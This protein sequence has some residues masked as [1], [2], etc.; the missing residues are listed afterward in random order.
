MNE[1]HQRC[2]PAATDARIVSEPNGYLASAACCLSGLSSLAS[3]SV[4]WAKKPCRVRLK[5]CALP[6][7][8][9]GMKLVVVSVSEAV[10]TPVVEHSGKG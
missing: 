5:Q 2:Q 8:G 1:R 7:I 4:S 10:G 6:S 9:D 3:P